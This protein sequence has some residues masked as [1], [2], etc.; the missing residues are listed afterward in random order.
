MSLFVGIHLPIIAQSS[1]GDLAVTARLRKFAAG[2]SCS[3]S[4]ISITI[5]KVTCAYQID[6]AANP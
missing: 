3:L 6:E 4:I 1:N 5:Q 2:L